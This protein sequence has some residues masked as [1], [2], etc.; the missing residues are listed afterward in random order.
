MPFELIMGIAGIIIFLIL[1]SYGS[2][3]AVAL[4]AVGVAG[5]VILIG[6]EQT[7]SYVSRTLYTEAASYSL[8]VLPL[9]IIMGH[10][11]KSA[12]VVEQALNVTTAWFQDLK[13][14][15]YWVIIGSSS[16]FAA[17]T[18]S[19]T[20]TTVAI[21]NAIYSPMV[22]SGFN[23]VLT[24]GCLAASGTIGVLIPP[25]IPLVVYGIAVEE[26]IGLL[27]IAGI[28]PGILEAVTYFIG[29]YVLVLFKP[30]LVP[31]KIGEMKRA[32]LKEK[33]SLLPQ[34]WGALTLFF[35]IIGG[36]YSGYFTPNEAGAVGAFAA[37]I[38][39][40]FRCKKNSFQEISTGTW[41]TVITTA[42]LFL[43]IIASMIFTNFL[44]LSGIFH[45]LRDLA[46]APLPTLIIFLSVFFVMGMFMS[47]T[48]ALLII[49]PIA[50][51]LL[52]SHYDP[53][54]LGVIMVK[55]FE[56]GAITPPVGFNIFV[57]KS[58]D[59]ELPMEDVYKGTTFFWAMDILNI[60][61]L[62]ALPQLIL[63]LPYSL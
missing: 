35:I 27:L 34:L 9:F 3:I 45:H 51:F 18:G 57:A 30:D 62:I 28:I 23:R 6:I 41:G 24:I 32:S 14:G 43:I 48:A 31:K 38:M 61:I 59:K 25:S 15:L 63:W 20:A 19:G 60:I 33:I 29:V 52:S 8:A 26:R 16:V 58:I 13:A 50:H 56:V 44:T 12:G 5:T 55:M 7:M 37:L 10:F 53:I 49:A 39:L 17:A 22:K 21:G 40:V 36:I 2:H 1:I 4:A 54:W 47:S 11:A 46:L 42:M